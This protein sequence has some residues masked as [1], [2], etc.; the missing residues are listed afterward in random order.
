MDSHAATYVGLNWLTVLV[1]LV[2][3]ITNSIGIVFKKEVFERWSYRVVWL[4]LFVHSCA[5]LYWWQLAGHGPYM[6]PSEILSSNAWCTIVTFFVFLR[7]FP[8][9]RPASIVV[10]PAAFL[11]VALG[12]IYNPGLRTL[13][14]TYGTIWLVIHILLYKISLSTLVIGLA[15]SILY[16]RKTRCKPSQ[17]LTRLPEPDIMDLYAYRF[18]GFGFIFWGMAM[19]AGSIWAY[20]SW[21]RFWGWDPVETWSLICWLSFGVYLHLRRFFGVKGR[22]AAWLFMSCFVIAIIAYYVTSHM[23]SSIHSEYFK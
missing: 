18:A 1:Y 7:L 8:A 17:W 22:V 19:L 5:I 21:G 13:P 23:G 20:K 15:F 9:I 14:P 4:G 12:N 16:L 10:F 2:A 6:A 11:L 3:I